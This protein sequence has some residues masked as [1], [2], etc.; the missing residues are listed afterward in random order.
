MVEIDDSIVARHRIAILN[1]LREEDPSIRRRALELVIAIVQLNNVEELVHDLLQYLVEIKEKE[2]RRDVVS[3]I[4]SLVQQFAPSSMWQVDTL[5][6]VLKMSG[7][8]ANDEVVSTLVEVVSHDSDELAC[9]TV[10]CAA[11]LLGVGAS[12]VRGGAARP[13]SGSPAA[14]RVVVHRRVRRSAG[15]ELRRRRLHQARGE[16]ERDA[17]ACALRRGGVE[18]RAGRAADDRRRPEC[19]ERESVGAADDAAEAERPL[20]R[21]GGGG[22]QGVLGSVA[23]LQRRGVETASE[24]VLHPAGRG[25]GGG[26]ESAAGPNAAA[27]HRH[28]EDAA[29]GERVECGERGGRERR[30]R[31]RGGG[32]RI[33]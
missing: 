28:G 3:K 12:V 25:R 29:E 14:E 11:M 2:E 18:G 22:H 1:C 33:G 21:R 15:R 7:N 31:E 9:Y 5:L 30:G 16:E 23:R 4:T 17:E 8:E 26:A 6:S 20:R 13:E 19:V 24:R 32:R 10:H 27:G